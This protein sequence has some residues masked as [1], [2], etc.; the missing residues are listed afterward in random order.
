MLCVYQFICFSPTLD[1]GCRVISPCCI[2]SLSK[3]SSHPSIRPVQCL[4][5]LKISAI[6]C[7]FACLPRKSA[8]SLL[9]TPVASSLLTAYPAELSHPIWGALLLAISSA[10]LYGNTVKPEWISS[11]YTLKFTILGCLVNE[12]YS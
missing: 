9:C 12:F 7:I 3:C 4:Q 10:R 8:Y 1:V 11:I 5:T 2:L 6:H